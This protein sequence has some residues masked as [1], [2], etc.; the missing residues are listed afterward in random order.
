MQKTYRELVVDEIRKDLENSLMGNMLEMYG[1]FKEFIEEE[2]EG[3]S[4]EFKEDE[5]RYTVVNY[6]NNLGGFEQRYTDNLD[7]I[8]ED[9]TVVSY[10]SWSHDIRALWNNQDDGICSGDF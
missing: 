5:V 1:S 4:Q 2:Y 9:G 8:E 3:Y 10:R 7:I 6:F